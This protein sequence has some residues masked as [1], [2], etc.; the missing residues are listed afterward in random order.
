[1][2][3]Q[4]RTPTEKQVALAVSLGITTAG[5]SFRVLSAEIADAMERR[6]FATIERDGIVPGT[7]VEYTGPRSDLAG[8]WRVSS[9][10]RDGFLH[11]RRTPKYCR[12]WHVRAVRTRVCR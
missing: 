12:P 2:T 5:K 9:V 10:A 8:I 1:M 4:V 11:F 6:A 7:L 3:Y